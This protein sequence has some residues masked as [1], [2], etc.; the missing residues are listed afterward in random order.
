VI[1]IS[2]LTYVKTLQS[3]HFALVSTITD[4]EIFYTSIKKEKNIDETDEINEVSPPFIE[5]MLGSAECKPILSNLYV[6]QEVRCQILK[7]EY[8]E[9]HANVGCWIIHMCKDTVDAISNILGS[10]S[11]NPDQ[12]EPQVPQRKKEFISNSTNQHEEINLQSYLAENDKPLLPPP[13]IRRSSSVKSS[14]IYHTHLNSS[15]LRQTN[16]ID[17]EFHQLQPQ[18]GFPKVKISL[19]LFHL[20]INLYSGKDFNA[21]RAITPGLSFICENLGLSYSKFPQTLNYS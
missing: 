3:L 5:C 20:R 11:K 10:F 8:L 15:Q 18:H 4:L 17:S 19:S 13:L 14:Q 16:T 1:S 7:E 2:S 12:K 6:S 21:S 9:V